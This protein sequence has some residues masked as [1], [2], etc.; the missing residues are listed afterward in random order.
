[1]TKEEILEKQFM[2]LYEPDR[3]SILYC[4]Q[5]YADQ[6]TSELKAELNELKKRHKHELSELLG[7]KS[8]VEL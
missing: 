6:Q 2:G 1:M 5:E 3:L 4:M 7:G 8:I